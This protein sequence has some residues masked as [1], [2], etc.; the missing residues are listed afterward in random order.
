MKWSNIPEE[1][2][3]TL[4]SWKSI[5]TN[6]DREFNVFLVDVEP[7]YKDL[8]E[9]GDFNDAGVYDE[10]TEFYEVDLS[11]P[12]M[13]DKRF[14]GLQSNIADGLHRIMVA[15]HKGTRKIPAIDMTPMF[16]EL[17]LPEASNEYQ[18]H[19]SKQIHDMADNLDPNI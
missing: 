1:I 7:L 15:H 11:K 9:S 18:T 19:P 6:Y 16:L 3:E 10:E 17:G 13:F 12:I 4:W 5:P 8:S 2:Q 14:K